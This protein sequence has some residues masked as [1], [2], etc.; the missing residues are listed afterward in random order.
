[1]YNYNIH[2]Q[3]NAGAN[4]RKDFCFNLWILSI[5]KDTKFPNLQKEYRTLANFKNRISVILTS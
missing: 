4:N 2:T 1:M 5:W 3:I